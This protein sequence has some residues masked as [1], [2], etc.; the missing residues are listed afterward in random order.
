[1]S[2]ITN[3]Q[4]QVQKFSDGCGRGDKKEHSSAYKIV[5]LEQHPCLWYSVSSASLVPL[6]ILLR[7][8]DTLV[9][10][11]ELLPSRAVRSST[12]PWFGRESVNNVQGGYNQLH[13]HM[14][15]IHT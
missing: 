4:C 2:R 14:T 6:L 1:M 11:L 3:L 12:G 15:L 13:I 9:V 7:G 8:D 5:Q 10:C